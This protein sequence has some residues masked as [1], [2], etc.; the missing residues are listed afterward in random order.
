V[1]LVTSHFRQLAAWDGLTGRRLYNRRCLA[2]DRN[3][4]E[5]T[6]WGDAR[7]VAHC[8]SDMQVVD[9]RDGGILRSFTL[10]QEPWAYQA[11]A[12]AARNS[13]TPPGGGGVCADRVPL[14]MHQPRASPCLDVRC[15]RVKA[16]LPRGGKAPLPLLCFSWPDIPLMLLFCSG[17]QHSGRGIAR[18]CGDSPADGRSGI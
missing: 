4:L 14:C 6:V 5:L 9:A 10:E 18:A 2:K 17:L 8:M 12:A 13:E 3:D 15:P 11:S 7:V 1:I 16:M